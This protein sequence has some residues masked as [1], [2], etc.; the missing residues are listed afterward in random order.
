MSHIQGTRERRLDGRDGGRPA[1]EVRLPPLQDQGAC[2]ATTTSPRWRRCSPGGSPP[3]SP[4]ATSR[5]PS[6]AGKF[7]YPPKLLLVDGGKGQL[8]VAVRVLEELGLDDEIPVAALAK[9]FEEVYVPGRGRPDPH[10][11]PVRGAVPAAAD[12]RRGPPVRHHVPPPAARQA[13]DDES[14]LDDIPGLGPSAQ[15]AAGQ[16]ARRRQ[17]GEA[18]RR[19]RSS[20]ALPWLPDAVAD[21]R[22]TSSSTRRRHGRGRCVARGGRVAHAADER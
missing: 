5:S 19:S 9:R 4:S 17:R 13:H 20:Q 18:R 3:T 10:P 12:P 7:A 6:A 11:P 1:E 21:A 16:G 15:E 22:S 14:V 2:R 8:G